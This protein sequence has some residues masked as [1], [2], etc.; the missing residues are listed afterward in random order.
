MLIG[1]SGD[2]T[3]FTTAARFAPHGHGTDR[4]L[5][6]WTCHPPPVAARNRRGTYASHIAAIT[7]SATRTALDAPHD[8]RKLAEGHTPREAIRALERRL[9]DV[10]WHH[11][12]ADIRR[13]N[14]CPAGPGRT[15]QERLCR[16]RGRLTP[17]H[18]LFGEVTTRTLK[19]L[20]TTGP[21]S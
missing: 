2:P 20:S 17:E 6:R 3:Q 13:V 12:I 21:P 4:V 1:Y 11:L 9:S 10:V 19:S 5:H 14:G 15:L 8:D 16:L 18:R 7:R